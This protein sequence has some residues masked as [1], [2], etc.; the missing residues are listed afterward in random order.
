MDL[1]MDLVAWD[2]AVGGP[3]LGD[4]KV[5]LARI[6]GS[7]SPPTI[8]PGQ[9]SNLGCGYAQFCHRYGGWS[10]RWRHT[11]RS[12]LLLNLSNLSRTRQRI[13]KMIFTW[14]DGKI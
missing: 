14:I 5:T 13:N 12:V 7:S 6:F 4:L 11:H 9:S 8:C 3:L 1:V 10:H 2:Q